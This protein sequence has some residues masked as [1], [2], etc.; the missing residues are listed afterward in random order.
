MMR[1]KIFCIVLNYVNYYFLVLRHLQLPD[2]TI[3]STGDIVVIDNVDGE[4]FVAVVE[5][6]YDNG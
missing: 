3:V 1:Q 4:D 5:H 6:F 2:Q